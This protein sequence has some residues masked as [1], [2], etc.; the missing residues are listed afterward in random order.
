MI[1][2][3]AFRMLEGI[4]TFFNPQDY[5]YAFDINTRA[6]QGAGSLH[7]EVY[8]K[9]RHWTSTERPPPSVE[10]LC[11]LSGP[12]SEWKGVIE[13]TIPA[14]FEEDET[15]VTT[16]TIPFESL[17]QL[18]DACEQI[19]KTIDHYRVEGQEPNP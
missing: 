15:E 19:V 14:T 17:P 10:A 11:P 9:H 16:V 8:P 2:K 6:N 3:Q 1:T 12:M 13:L 4:T 7:V 5:A 18:K